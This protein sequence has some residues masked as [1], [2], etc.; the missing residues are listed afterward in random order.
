[1]KIAIR[2]GYN[3]IDCRSGQPLPIPMKESTMHLL[4]RLLA[5]ILLVFAL[6]A[7]VLAA[8]NPAAAD[9]PAVAG[10]VPAK[11]ELI[12]INSA[13]EVQLKSLPG[14]GEAYAAKIVAGRPYAKKNQLK[15]KN[16][17]PAA[18]YDKI[19]DRVIAR[20]PGR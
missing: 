17:I 19:Q 1:L 18:T 2:D 10:T 15:S 14:I 5:A 4:T 7:P 12:D 11:A 9:Q 8:D 20:Q 16:I 6:A 13:S 3:V